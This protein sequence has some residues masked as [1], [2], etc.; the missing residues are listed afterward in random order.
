MS[1]WIRAKFLP[2]KPLFSGKANVTA[3]KEHLKLSKEAASE[4]MV[5]LKN[6]EKVLPIKKDQPVALFGKAIFDYVKGGG[7]SGDVTVEYV[8]NFY[9][10]LKIINPEISLFEESVSYYKGYVE[11]QYQAGEVPGMM[12]EPELPD[13]LVK[14]A[15]DFCDTAIVAISRFSGEAWDRK[16]VFYENQEEGEAII[17]QKAMD[18]FGESDYYLTAKEKEMLSKVSSAFSKVILILNIGGIIDTR[19]LKENEKIQSVLLS[20]NGGMEGGLA[21]AELIYGLVNPSG[22]LPDTFADSLEAYPSTE[23]F[24]ED[25][26]YVNYKEDIYV[27]YRYFETI[28]DA[29][30]HVVYPF[31]FGLSY[32]EFEITAPELRIDGEEITV[33]V[34]VTNIGERAGKEVVQL[35]LTPPQGLLG[36]AKKN[37][38]AF[39]KTDLLEPGESQ[40]IEMYVNYYQMASY[41]DLGKIE[42]SA[43]VLEKGTYE[44]YVGNSVRNVA[45]AEKKLIL[46]HDV[47]IEKLS[48]QGA[49]RELSER[50]RADGSYEPLPLREAFDTDYNELIPFDHL[51]VDNPETPYVQRFPLNS[52]KKNVQLEDVVDGR[53]KMED[54]IGK[55]SDIQLARLL[56]GQPNTGVA[57]TF[58]FGN[59]EEYGIPNFMT[60]DGPAGVRI[61]P[62]CEVYTTAWPCATLLA[63]SWNSEI[64]YQVGV[65]AA[66]EL[67]ENNLSIW[68]APA[69]N[70]H[71]NPLCGRNFEYY[72]ED[73]VL[74]GEL[75]VAMIS[76]VQSQGVAATAKHFCCNNKETNRRSS[77]SRVSERALRE[78]YLKIFEILVKKTDLLC[79]MTSYNIVNGKRASE[80]EEILTEILRNEWGFEGIVMTDWWNFGEH[81]KELAAGNDIKMGNGFPDRLMEALEKGLISRKDMERSV[82]RLFRVFGYLD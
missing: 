14:K 29:A 78:I 47:V 49:P 34:K 35:Y 36:K 41:D 9:D 23:T 38:L 42:K 79:I 58:G 33:N 59:L 48:S 63:S 21:T 16:A 55:L 73:P 43:Y 3:S 56:G 71:R 80:N 69:V 77:D 30:S 62:E 52:H 40:E 66:R 50:L 75:A 37:L 8:H 76:G 68:L 39:E 2:N 26:S 12:R 25:A 81:Y 45:L 10:G 82:K 60:A 4:G 18:L 65:A 46:E 11:G 7:G 19:W 17:T 67:K 72:S 51:I 31:G 57:N 20:W 74:G 24:L 44:F 13:E 53:V 61:L 1:K 6:E 64:C 54:L 15:S 70:I 5:L 27:G 28:P 32:T 22:K